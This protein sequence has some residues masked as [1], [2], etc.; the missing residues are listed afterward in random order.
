MAHAHGKS[1]VI[2]ERLRSTLDATG[3]EEENGGSA[4]VPECFVEAWSSADYKVLRI[5]IIGL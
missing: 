1:C 2:A 3:G 4:G 5:M